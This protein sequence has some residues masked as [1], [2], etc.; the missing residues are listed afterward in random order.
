[1]HAQMEA[2]QLLDHLNAQI[3][4]MKAALL[5]VKLALENV[6]NALAV[7]IFHRRPRPVSIVLTANIQILDQLP[8]LLAK[9]VRMTSVRLVLDLEVPNATHAS[10]LTMLL[11]A[12]ASL[13]KMLIVRPVLE[14]EPKSVLLVLLVMLC[15]ME[16]VLFVKILDVVLA[17][18][19][20][21]SNAQLVKRIII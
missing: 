21:L 15:L 19:L 16:L 8:H 6:A 9:I 7:T 14:M 18:I 11:E 10:I 5:V 17:L 1:L 2:I 4:G 12:F 3:V 20:E 13:V